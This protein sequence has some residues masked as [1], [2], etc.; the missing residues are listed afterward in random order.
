VLAAAAVLA[1][2]AGAVGCRRGAREEPFL[3]YFN[4]EHALSV[5]YPA[6]WTTEQAQQGETMY[7]YFRSPNIGERDRKPGVTVTL[8]AT[9]LTGTIDQY[10]QTALLGQTIST[11]R[12][13]KRPG[14]AGK[15]WL[16]VS[17][18]GATR[19][20]LLLL[21]EEGRLYGLH[22]QGSAEGYRQEEQALAEVM[23][24][25]ALER[26]AHYTEDHNPTY[27]YALRVP[28]S[29]TTARAFSGGGTLLK[30]FTSPPLGVDKDGQTAHA[31]L[32]L[33]V[34]A[35]PAGATAQ[36]FYKSSND[37]LGEAFQLIS[38]SEWKDGFVDLLRTETPI[39]ESRGKRF[40][41]VAEGRGYTL[42]FEAR[43]DVYPRVSRWC[44]MIA[45]SFRA[46]A[47]LD[48]K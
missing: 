44:D 14:A 22:A 34:E 37:K 11:V 48:P 17:P 3:T 13:E 45:N 8:I 47:E 39:A 19:H 29:W 30:Q 5:R 43:G 15:T 46:G 21:Q 20:Q 35:L 41:R 2:A 38:H 40:Y 33:T 18:D 7:R 4:A 6:S 9:P 36:S 1:L 32:T 24:G 23:K 12:D 31:S 25:F 28:P 42:S 10:A 16:A 27:R 26:W